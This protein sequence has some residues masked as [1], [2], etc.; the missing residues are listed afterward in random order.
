M[1]STFINSFSKRI[2]ILGIAL[3]I[4]LS[5]CGGDSDPVPPTGTTP[6]PPAQTI[7]VSGGGV[8]GPLANAVVTVLAFDSFLCNLSKD[9]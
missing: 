1:I 6:P 7:S 3:G 2:S 5:G 4:G 9:S 8:K